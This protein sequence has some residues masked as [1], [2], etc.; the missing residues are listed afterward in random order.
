MKTTAVDFDKL[1]AYLK[2]QVGW[3]EV[4]KVRKAI[5]SRHTDPRKLEAMRFVGLLERDGNN[6]KLTTPDGRAF[7]AGDEVERGE[8]MRR[9]L[10]S[11]PLY[12]ATLDW[13]HFNDKVD[14]SKTDIANCW[15]D[16]HATET[17]GAVGDSL[18]DATVF[19]MRVVDLAQ[20]G[21]FIAAGTG[22]DTHL[23]MDPVALEEFATGTAPAAP[24]PSEPAA[25]PDAPP[26][27]SAPPPQVTLGT[28]LNVNVE[29]HI[30]ADAKPA[31]IEEIFRNM[32]K[33]LIDQC[34][35]TNG[36]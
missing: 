16:N 12:S 13:M 34:D 29:I 22:R 10:K 1:A 6:V 28:G 9:R 35:P 18:T 25:N 27:P 3:V 14:V 26:P 17:G 36:G 21:R 11:I 4:D 19:F 15:H 33:Y 31:T 20:L 30:A 5:P 7:A 23:E 24:R 2:N 8:I 32:R